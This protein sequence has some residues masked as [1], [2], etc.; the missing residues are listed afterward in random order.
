[1]KS[2]HELI[3]EIVHHGKGGDPKSTAPVTAQAAVATPAVI[4]PAESQTKDSTSMN[5]LETLLLNLINTAAI[6]APSLIH[7]DKGL[8][9]LNASE[10][11]LAGILASLHPAPAPVA[12]APTVTVPVGSSVT[13][14]Q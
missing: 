6:T 1:M 4:T 8:I 11:F 7:S 12:P 2:V 14:T 5:F 3:N 9:I 10:T 13:V